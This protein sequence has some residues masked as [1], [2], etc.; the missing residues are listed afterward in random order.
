M[1]R[2]HKY[3]KIKCMMT[4]GFTTYFTTSIYKKRLDPNRFYLFDGGILSRKK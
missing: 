3:M 2:K 4:K 1:H